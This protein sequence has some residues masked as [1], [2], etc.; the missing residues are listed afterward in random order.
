MPNFCN[1]T[2]KF[3]EL[4]EIGKELN[5]IGK[6]LNEIGKKLNEIGKELNEIGSTQSGEKFFESRMHFTA[7]SGT[8][9]GRKRLVCRG[10]E[11]SGGVCWRRLNLR[12][13]EEDWRVPISYTS[14]A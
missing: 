8:V 10:N 4:N 11:W 1:I 13:R 9:I 14:F 2:S 5:E 7:Q 12:D 3:K 6:E